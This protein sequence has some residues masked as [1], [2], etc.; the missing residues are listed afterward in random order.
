MSPCSHND[1][2]CTIP[3]NLLTNKLVILT[4]LLKITIIIYFIAQPQGCQIYRVLAD[5]I[6][7]LLII[8]LAVYNYVI[9]KDYSLS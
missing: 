9:D 2:I 4:I 6:S 7:I 3:C 8:T 1:Q 5:T